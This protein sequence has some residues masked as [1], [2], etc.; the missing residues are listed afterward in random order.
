MPLSFGSNPY[1][2]KKVLKTREL[3][4]FAVLDQW[5]TETQIR[6][7]Q[8]HLYSM[9]PAWH[10]I[11]CENIVSL[12]SFSTFYSAYWQANNNGISSFSLQ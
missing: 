5:L 11:C 2:W 9:I 7:I 4:S 1:T 3:L 8:S 10:K 12:A 6:Q